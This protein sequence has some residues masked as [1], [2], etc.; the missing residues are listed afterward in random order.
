MVK[1]RMMTC[2]VGEDSWDIFSATETVLVITLSAKIFDLAW[3][4]MYFRSQL[5][6][7]SMAKKFAHLI[8]H[9]VFTQWCQGPIFGTCPSIAP[10]NIWWLQ[11]RKKS[12]VTDNV[13][14]GRLMIMQSVLF[15]SWTMYSLHTFMALI[16][17][18]FWTWFS[19]NNGK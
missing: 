19:W 4:S 5:K 11:C 16:I 9:N 7:I 3:K 10:C 2:F 12:I 1:W 17:T 13:K 8:V 18:I 6:I 14:N 15:S